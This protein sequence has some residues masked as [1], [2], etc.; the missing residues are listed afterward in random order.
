VE[1]A[2]MIVV[3]N[4]V[5][6]H[7]HLK[8]E[9]DLDILKEEE[10]KQVHTLAVMVV[11]DKQDHIEQVEER[12][13]AYQLAHKG[14]LQVEHR[15]VK[16]QIVAYQLA[17]KGRLQVQKLALRYTLLVDTQLVEVYTHQKGLSLKHL[18]PLGQLRTREEE[19]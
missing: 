18:L 8:F 13:V 5:G 3:V 14:R 7:S 10:L 2:V 11:F 16:E 4:L 17:H 9:E 15:M 12:I 19:H 1:V 6:V